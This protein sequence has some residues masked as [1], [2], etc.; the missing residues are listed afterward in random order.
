M[1]PKLKEW[2]PDK[3]VEQL[4]QDQLEQLHRLMFN[5]DGSLI[6]DCGLFYPPEFLLHNK[7]SDSVFHL[8]EEEL[9]SLGPLP[10]ELRGQ[11]L[12]PGSPLVLMGLSKPPSKISEIWRRR[13]ARLLKS[14]R[15]RAALCLLAR[16]QTAV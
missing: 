3:F 16:S 14:A 5:S 11:S 9:Q 2:L 4:S 12:L 10:E 1:K 6:S 8:T 15:Q 7:R 13:L